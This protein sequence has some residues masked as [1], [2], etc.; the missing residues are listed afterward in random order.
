M[1]SRFGAGAEDLH[2]V[3]TRCLTGI[4]GTTG[5]LGGGWFLGRLGGGNGGFGRCRGWL[6]RRGC[7][8]RWLGGSDL[9]RC[10]DR[11]GRRGRRRAGRNAR[12]R[13]GGGDGRRSLAGTLKRYAIVAFSD[14]SGRFGQRT[15]HDRLRV[16][17]QRQR[18]RLRVTGEFDGWRATVRLRC[19]LAERQLRLFVG[20]STSGRC[21][22]ATRHQPGGGY[23]DHDDGGNRQ[24]V[25]LRH[26][27]PHTWTLDR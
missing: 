26:V 21:F 11:F 8:R 9:S 22:A 23:R 20:R 1:R 2:H 5:S 25:F 14:I 13:R 6:G 17:D 18:H 24:Y 15:T 4:P 27:E 16:T 7:N 12:W 10:R 19:T 3:V